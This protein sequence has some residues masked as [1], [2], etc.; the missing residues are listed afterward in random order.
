[1]RA[2]VLGATGHI[3]AHVV[4]ALLAEGYEVRAAYRREQYLPV[5]E[6]LPVERVRVDLQTQEGLRA[7]LQ[8][9][10]W[11]F[12]AAGDYPTLRERG[13]MALARA[14]DSTQRLLHQLSEFAPQRIVFTSSAAT[15]PRVPGRAATE[16]DTESAVE[17]HGLYAT[18]KMAMEREVLRACREQRLPIVI[19]NPSVC[20][21][22]YDS[23]PMSGRLILVFATGRMPW[24]LEHEFNVVYTG[25]GGLGHVRAAQRGRVGERYL[26]TGEQIRL[27]AFAKLVARLAGVRPPRWRIPHAMV[28]AAGLASE[29][30]AWVTRTEPMIPRRAVESLRA[31]QR[32][33][34]TKAHRE[35][36]LSPM[37]AEE[38][39]RRAL[40][41]FRQ[42]GHLP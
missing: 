4:R 25:D 1:M 12:H 36:G 8:G 16:A 38:A 33:D 11:V 21:G 13:D 7:A 9:C 42:H 30:L 18:V 31:I 19:V 32:L 17:G 37:P 3:G 10:A 24:Y 23:R 14:V 27:E 35:F 40:A 28:Q 41:W 22:E 26:L 20:L 5:L 15:I 39:A 2:L 34:G 29:G 6:G